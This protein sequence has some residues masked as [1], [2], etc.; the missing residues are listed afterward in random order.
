MPLRLTS[1]CNKSLCDC[2]LTWPLRLCVNLPLHLLCSLPVL[3]VCAGPCVQHPLS[4]PAHIL[5]AIDPATGKPL[6]DCQAKAE[7]A[8]FMAAGFETTSHAITWTLTMLVR[9]RVC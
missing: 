1:M 2:V 5:S 6:D 4:V 9:S 7:I 3:P 8:T